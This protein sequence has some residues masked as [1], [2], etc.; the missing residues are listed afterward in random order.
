MKSHALNN[1]E[2]PIKAAT[3][4]KGKE[5]NS[6]HSLEVIEGSAK[7]GLLSTEC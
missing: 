1:S 3:M 5:L 7:S 2:H 4:A 6:N